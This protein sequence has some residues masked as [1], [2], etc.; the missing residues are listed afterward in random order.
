VTV[1]AGPIV[2]W[3]PVRPVISAGVALVTDTSPAPQHGD[4][5][6]LVVTFVKEGSGGVRSVSN[7]TGFVSSDVDVVVVALA[8][9]GASQDLPVLVMVSPVARIAHMVTIQP[10]KGQW[11]SSILTGCTAV[12]LTLEVPGTVVAP[13]LLCRKRTFFVGN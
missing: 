7:V 12:T 8:G 10:Q 1:G 4:M 2:A 3:D 6:T 9:S 11:P 13:F 5:V